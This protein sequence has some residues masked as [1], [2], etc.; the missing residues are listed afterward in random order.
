[1]HENLVLLYISGEFHISSL[2]SVPDVSYEKPKTFLVSTSYSFF[3]LLN[4][5]SFMPNLKKLMF[6]FYFQSITFAFSL[7]ILDVYS[8]KYIYT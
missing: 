3:T 2:R 1:M 5:N 8:I 6:D 7:F 4:I